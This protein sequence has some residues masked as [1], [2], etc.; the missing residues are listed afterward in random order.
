M[1]GN[2]EGAPR[3][4]LCCCWN[5][6]VSAL[7]TRVLLAPLCAQACFWKRGRGGERV[8]NSMCDC[9]GS[10]V[11]VFGEL[12]FIFVTEVQETDSKTKITSL[13]LKIMHF[14]QKQ[15]KNQSQPMTAYLCY[16]WSPVHSLQLDTWIV[17][18]S[19]NNQSKR[20]QKAK[21]NDVNKHCTQLLLLTTL[22][23]RLFKV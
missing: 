8:E 5:V 23:L 17:C 1:D 20:L 7:I 15:P 12:E 11:C 14:T 18:F 4:K 16:W 22:F 6:Q 10:C 2:R 3:S 9:G 13:H 19:L 21:L